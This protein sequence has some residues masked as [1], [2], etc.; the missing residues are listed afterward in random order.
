MVNLKN[1]VLQ[2]LT[3]NGK[4]LELLKGG[5]GS[6]GKYYSVDFNYKEYYQY[7][8]TMLSAVSA[9]MGIFNTPLV[10][11]DKPAKKIGLIDWSSELNSSFK[12]FF[13]AKEN[14]IFYLDSF[15]TVDESFS[16]HTTESSLASQINQ[17][18]DIANE[19]KF[20]FGKGGNVAANLMNAGADISSSIGES[21]EGLGSHL[22]G[23]IVGSITSKGVNSIL[24]GGK[25]I[26]PKIWQD[27]DFDRSFSFN[28]KLRSP[29]HDKLSIFLNVIKPYCKLLALCMTRQ[30]SVK[31]ANSYTAPFLV[32]CYVKGMVNVE[33]GM[34]SSISATKGAECQWTDDGLPTQIDV[35][36]Q[37]ED[38]YSQLF[39]S[40][41]YSNGVKENGINFGNN[42]GIYGM[43]NN[44]SYMDFLANMAGLNLG[45][46]EL[47]RRFTMMTYLL[48]TYT[49]TLPSNIMTGIEESISKTIRKI[50]DNI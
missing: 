43:V 38:L 11:G 17:F 42:S 4:A 3:G 2:S 20:L 9:Y 24:N 30:L 21:L 44:T 50:Y 46:M 15:N 19:L 49:G 41:I 36:I 47:G 10:V 12:T 16:N 1:I 32:K 40:N 8:N 29:D 14:V 7:V 5:T 37:I 28:I 6:S 48:Q 45:Q 27:S 26:F 33:M 39:M 22:G 35:S 18:S 34:I 13:S 31:D 23:G 25:I